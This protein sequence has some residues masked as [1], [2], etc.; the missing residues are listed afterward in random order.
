MTLASRGTH[1]GSELLRGY[2]PELKY[3]IVTLKCAHDAVN[4]LQHLVRNTN[5][6]RRHGRAF[7]DDALL[8]KTT[9]VA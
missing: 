8:V 7:N 5:A 1:S 9:L 6:S 3:P 2:R 4:A